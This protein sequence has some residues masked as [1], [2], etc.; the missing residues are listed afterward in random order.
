MRIWQLAAAIGVCVATMQTPAAAE[1]NDGSRH[2]TTHTGAPVTPMALPGASELD[3]PLIDASIGFGFMP[4]NEVATDTGYDTDSG[5]VLF[6]MGLQANLQLPAIDLDDNLRLEGGMGGSLWFARDYTFIF[7][8]L[9]RNTTSTLT[10]VNLF[11]RG[12]LW[13]GQM[14]A[15]EVDLGYRFIESGIWTSSSTEIRVHDHDPLI[16]IGL[17]LRLIDNGALRLDLHAAWLPDP[18]EGNNDLAAGVRL[19]YRVLTIGL[20]ASGVPR[21]TIKR[22]SDFNNAT[23]IL[24]V[25]FTVGLNLAF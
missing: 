16:S 15:A 11:G 8:L 25:M 17:R 21:N 6:M 20:V 2:T 4:L 9:T 23:T 22:G 5:N 7:E 18:A 1:L 19:D 12:R 14:L 10:V 13:F 3:A 24:G